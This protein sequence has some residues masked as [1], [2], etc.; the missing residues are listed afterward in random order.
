MPRANG[1][2]AWP[3]GGGTTTR[4]V[5][6]DASKGHPDLAQGA[7]KR[8]C[9]GCLAVWRHRG[10][11]NLPI[12]V[13]KRGLDRSTLTLSRPSTDSVSSSK[14]DEVMNKLLS[15]DHI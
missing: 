4:L 13:H 11:G 15:V 5:F 2:L 6:E 1:P 3:D 8:K 14:K 7:K 10:T 9:L 12:A